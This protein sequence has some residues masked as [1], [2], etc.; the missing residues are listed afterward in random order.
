MEESPSSTRL[1]C[2][3][4]MDTA[5]VERKYSVGRMIAM[6]PIAAENEVAD[7]M[8]ECA[9]LSMQTGYRTVTR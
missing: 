9:E 5:C 2:E 7:N 8:D 1:S 3:F 6:D 4:H